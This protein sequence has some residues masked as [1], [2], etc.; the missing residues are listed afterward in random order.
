[1]T[2]N[3]LDF[4]KQWILL[5]AKVSFFLQS[6]LVIKL[7]L[8][9]ILLWFYLSSCG[10]ILVKS[11]QTQHLMSNPV[12]FSVVDNQVLFPFSFIAKWM[13]FSPV[14]QNRNRGFCVWN[15]SRQMLKFRFTLSLR[16]AFLLFNGTLHVTISR[17]LFLPRYYLTKITLPV[18][19]TIAWIKACMKNWCYY[20]S[21]PQNNFLKGFR[22]V[23]TK[24]LVKREGRHY[25]YWSRT[26]QSGTL[27]LTA[28]CLSLHEVSFFSKAIS[29]TKPLFQWGHGHI[30]VCLPTCISSVLRFK[31]FSNSLMIRSDEGLTLETSAF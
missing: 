25:L 15:L 29:L 4:L 5:V 30:I 20:L 17:W 27:R 18:R 7:P 13:Y 19:N 16:S 10:L 6:C 12:L 23:N 1:M 8:H 11:F 2:R 22:A 14:F 24:G 3:N 9:D 28:C 21:I 31:Q 26:K